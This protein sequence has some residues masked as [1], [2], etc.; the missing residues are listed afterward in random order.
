M[1]TQETFFERFEYK[2]W[3]T[4]EMAEELL[5]I[6]ASYLRCDDWAPGGQHNTSLYLDSP[7]FDFAK[8]HTESAPDRVKLRV[9][10][11]GDPPAGSA[12]FEIKRKVKAVILKRRA[13]VPLDQMARV[14]TCL[15]IPHLKTP[16]EE[17]T[18]SQF[19][20]LTLVH[21]AEPKI[22]VT[23]RREAYASIDKSEGVRLTLDR[24]ICYQPTRELSLVGA[25]NSWVP[26][27][28]MSSAQPGATTLIEIKFRGTAPFWMQEVVQRLG[29]VRCNYSKYVSAV[30][31]EEGGEEGSA[32]G[33]AAASERWAAKRAGRA[34]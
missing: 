7:D 4:H 9:R 26:L 19:L 16:E 27:C 10:A 31:C 34:A 2:Y 24:N 32:F 28:G 30:A 17:Q 3:V 29:L 22:L 11:Y 21:R 13:I 20:Y 12:F 33:R 18:L 25:P 6:T 5:R 1:R 14:I 15:E 8:M 23:C